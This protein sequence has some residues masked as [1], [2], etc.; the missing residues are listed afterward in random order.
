M[1]SIGETVKTFI[2]AEFLQGEDP[3]NLTD[4]TPLIS[5]GILD[6]LATLKLV[7]FLEERYGIA[8]APH[9]TDEEYLGNL[10][11]IEQFVQSKL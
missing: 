10:A 11:A 2:L 3:K 4:S 6:S 8:V 9:E 7:A 1:H 5:T